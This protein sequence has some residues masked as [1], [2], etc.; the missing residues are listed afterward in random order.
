MFFKYI[1]A[2]LVNVLVEA[3]VSH[4]TVNDKSWNKAVK[5]IKKM[6]T[7]QHSTNIVKKVA[8]FLGV[9]NDDNNLDNFMKSI[10]K[11]KETVKFIS[12]PIKVKKH[13]IFT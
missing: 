5:E 9:Y 6:Y 13:L 11:L 7:A 12:K 10:V 1:L 2:T 3:F 4:L 8:T